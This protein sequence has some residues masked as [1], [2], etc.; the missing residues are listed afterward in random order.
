VI[1]AT[2]AGRGLKF[3]GRSE[4]QSL[5][6]SRM[7]P[8]GR[9][10]LTEK[11]HAAVRG[12]PQSEEHCRKIAAWREANPGWKSG[13][14]EA[15]LAV[16]LEDLGLAVTPQKAVGRYNVDLAVTETS[17]A[18]EV[19]GGNWHAAGAHAD[20]YRKRFDHLLDAGWLPVIIWVTAS[21]PLRV[22]A[23]NYVFALHEAVR[24]GE[25]RGRQEHVIRCD[26]ETGSVVEYEAADRPFV[27][28]LV[29]RRGAR[30]DDLG[31][32]E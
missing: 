29:P 25:P 26:A 23:A 1:N 22:G 32:G 9:L 28:G 20:R 31:P 10:E 6:L 8:E 2:L 19:F 24:R 3:R 4:A 7:T 14:A 30:G 12:V 21:Y 18:V 11:A 17:V 16:M 13:P 15:E 5:R 27:P